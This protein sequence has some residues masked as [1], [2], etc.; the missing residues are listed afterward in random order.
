MALKKPGM[1]FVCV[2]EDVPITGTEYSAT[3]GR[4]AKAGTDLTGARLILRRDPENLHDS[5]AVRVLTVP[6]LELGWIGM[7]TGHSAKVARILDHTTCVDAHLVVT[8]HHRCA[9]PMSR[10]RAALYVRRAQV[11]PQLA[12][13]IVDKIFQ[14][15][16]DNSLSHP[17]KDV[18]KPYAGKLLDLRTNTAR[19]SVSLATAE[20]HNVGWFRKS[21]V[22]S[23]IRINYNASV[24]LVITFDSVMLITPEEAEQFGY[25]MAGAAVDVLRADSLPA[26]GSPP[27]EITTYKYD[28]FSVPNPPIDP[29]NDVRVETQTQPQKETIMSKIAQTA[30]AVIESNKSAA[31]QAGYL[32]AGRLAN[33]QAAKLAGKHLPIMLRGYADT[34]IGQ[35]VIA[36]LAQIAVKQLRPNDPT[37]VKLTDAM[38]V[39]AFQGLYQTVDLDGIIDSL[40]SSTEMQRAVGKLGGDDA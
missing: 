30:T 18:L 5:N 23:A 33:K 1:D 9:D 36:N 34:A 35:L 12:G 4:V 28:K 20:G 21:D 8:H 2:L 32:E 39:Q 10:L 16:T 37:L 40:L 6:G 15:G 31:T 26:I 14:A 25:K 38:T 27:G 29:V 24:A 19:S 17:A 11:Q 22:D 3:Y 7:R 13:P